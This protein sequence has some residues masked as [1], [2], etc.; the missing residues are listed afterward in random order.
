MRVI[1][2]N[3]SHRLLIPM[4]VLLN[5]GCYHGRRSN[6]HI[7]GGEQTDSS[8]DRRPLASTVR[9][10]YIGSSPWSPDGDCTGTLIGPRHIVTAAHCLR[11]TM[12]P[13]ILSATGA[14][15][16]DGLK[17]TQHPLWGVSPHV[18]YDIGVISLSSE[19]PSA[20]AGETP[21]GLVPVTIAAPTRLDAGVMVILAGFGDLERDMPA[22][23]RLYQVRT[24]IARVNHS[25]REFETESGSGK[26]PC[27]GDS[28]GPAYL[29]DPEALLL[30]GATSH[31]QDGNCDSGQATYTDLT[32]FQGWL[33]CT[34]AAHNNPLESLANDDSATD[35]AL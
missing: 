17:A 7:V 34:F 33:K 11:N 26:G 14:M 31:N 19:V 35:C 30:V 20:K 1:S 28:G 10:R 21:F 5:L 18:T 22:L 3:R 12:L 16:L 15:S 9:L 32:R 6:L 2:M 25:T 24:R 4:C 8:S 23:N 29:E 27:H 13:E